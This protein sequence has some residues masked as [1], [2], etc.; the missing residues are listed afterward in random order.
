VAAPKITM[1]NL[2][3]SAPQAQEIYQLK[4]KIDELE[5]ELKQSRSN[6][7]SSDL[8]EELETRV[9]ELTRQLTAVSGEHEI[10]IALIDPDPDQPRKSFPQSVVQERA[11]SLRRHGQQT[12]IILIPRSTGRYSLFEG[13]LRTRG[14]TLLGWENLRAVFLQ[15]SLLPSQDEVLERQLIT[16]IHSSR[17]NDLDLAETIVRLL[18]HRH[19]T[20]E[21]ENIP[22]LLQSALYQL[23]RSGQLSD[24]EQIRIANESTQQQWLSDLNLKDSDEQKIL[25]LLLWL[26]LNPNSVKAHVFPLLNLPDDLKQAIRQV[27]IEPSK[28]RELNKLS[29]EFLGGTDD[30]ALKIRSQI[31]QKVIEEK[32]S[33]SQ[34][35]TLVKDTFSQPDPT[36]NVANQQMS[37][38]V[39]RIETIRIDGLESADLK[40]VRQ[41][42]QKKLKE[43]DAVLRK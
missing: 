4:A 40:E 8:K 1:K 24:L 7:G 29:S 31:L 6:V 26:Q 2:I 20:L 10:A 38:M 36:I 34:I 42:L 28:A 22:R 33:L 19:P 11:E 39:K 41:A 17:I 5:A 32:L 18:V 25:A 16:S 3:S 14:A 21:A 37:R 35:K 13:E 30:N 12:P 43:I 27:G 9:E 15:E 23:D